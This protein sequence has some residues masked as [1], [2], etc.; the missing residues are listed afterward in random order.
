MTGVSCLYRRP[1]GIY[2]VRLVVPV[3]LRLSVGR[4]E[5]HVSTGL[6]DWNA[7]KLAALKIQSYWREKFMTLDIEKLTAASP[8]LTGEGL[9][10]ISEAAKVIGL[11]GVSLLGELLNERAEIF[12]QAQHWQGWRVADIYSIERDFDGT[13][14]LNDVEEQGARETL[15][16]AVRPFDSPA[17]IATLLTDGKAASSIYRLPGHG[18]F[19]TDDEI[20]LPL[21][22][23]MAPKNV[24]ERIRVRLASGVPPAPRKPAVAPPTPVSG[25]VVVLDAMTAKHGHKRFSELFDLYRNH[26]TWSEDQKRRM[27]TEAGL[28]IE[29]MDDPQLSEIE[30]ETIHEYARRL[31]RLPNDIY[32]ARRR[33]KVE[34]LRELME[35]AERQSLPRKGQTTIRGHVGRIAEILN[36]GVKPA[37]MLRVN[38]AAGF[39]R[40]FGFSK[41]AR[42]QDE[43][44]PFTSEELALIFSQGWFASGAGA[45][46]AKGWTYWRPHY[47]W[48]PLLALTT[49]GRLNELAQLYLDDVRQS[50]K[51]GAVW[52]IDFNLNEPDKVDA[53]EGDYEP[54][55]SLKT[56]N[57]VRVVPLPDSVIQAGLPEYV[58]ALKKA[59]HVRLFPELKRD[60]VKGYGKPA[61]SWFNERFLGERLG[62]ERNGRKTFHS[63]RHNFATVVERL[64]IPERVM[65]QLL[66]H[67]RGRTQGATRYAKDRNAVELKPVID[68]LEFDCFAGVGKFD[69]SAAMKALKCAGRF[70]AAVARGREASGKV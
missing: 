19:W 4:G 66:G 17:T 56:I 9:I 12:T 41:K 21:S 58:A 25:G 8:L 61:G 11:S 28:F 51:D 7:A 53:D 15:A 62:I 39:K 49:G 65:A 70:K 10:P 46:S 24:I 67:E 63:L 34:P 16:G 1:S 60:R 13:F 69:V 50:E 57:A 29:L 26:K 27:A 38:P 64:D 44:D 33:F 59:G 23:W 40:D 2:A 52:Y 14:V 45:F 30:V 3:R 54:D 55:K 18:A 20:E 37:G 35:I 48:L 47:F 6:R 36:Y 43:R 32:L 31:S 5:I 68:R 42:A 22:A